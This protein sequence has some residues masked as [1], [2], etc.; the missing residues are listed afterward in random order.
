MSLSFVELLII[1]ILC[2]FQSVF[3]VGLLLFGTPIFLMLE[4]SFITT[5]ITI[6]PVSIIISFFQI[7]HKRNL[8]KTQM[9]EFNLHSLPFL[10]IFLILSINTKIIDIKLC[11]SLLLIV[12]SLITLSESKIIQWKKY[13]LNYKKYF[14]MLI[15]SIHGFTNMGGGFLS[16]F[17][18]IIHEN[19][20]FLARSYI[21][22]GY[23]IMGVI[24]FATLLIFS[25]KQIEIMNLLYVFI[26]ILVFF[27]SQQI[28]RKIDNLSFK[29]KISQIALIYGI[30]S[31]I[32]FI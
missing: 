19:N 13:I 20:K 25:N 29:R 24:Q 15:G 17:S 30:I 12:S 9:M 2:I 26:P 14:L 21:A 31:V 8:K 4:Y 22:Y 27:P 11:V 28:F 7:I 16:I 32:I 3:G 23:F 6:L 18:S 1:F 10:F 5:L